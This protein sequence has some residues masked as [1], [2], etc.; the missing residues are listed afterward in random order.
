MIIEKASFPL[1]RCV[2][3]LYLCMVFASLTPNSSHP[4]TV[5]LVPTER[6]QN[7]GSKKLLGQALASDHGTFCDSH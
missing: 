1:L 4:L 2:C 3:F 5:P 7:M 6:Q